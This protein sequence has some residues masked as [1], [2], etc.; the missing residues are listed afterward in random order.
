VIEHGDGLP[1]D[2]V[3]CLMCANLQ[4]RRVSHCR[5]Y[6]MDVQPEVPLRCLGFMPLPQAA[7]QRTGSERWP[8][9]LADIEEMRRLEAGPA[10][11]DGVRR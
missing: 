2:R 8:T 5:R 9:M 4:Q 10:S 7:D 11:K 3:T 1:D 6:R